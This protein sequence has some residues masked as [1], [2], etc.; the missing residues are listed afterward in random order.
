[1]TNQPHE[2]AFFGPLLLDFWNQQY[3]QS[4]RDNRPMS[5]EGARFRH[6]WAGWCARR[7]QYEI[8]NRE[9]TRT[10]TIPARPPADRWRLEM[11]T[12]VH[13]YWQAALQHALPDAT[14]EHVTQ[15]TLDNDD[16]SA[17][18]G[19]AVL[20]HPEFGKICVELKTRN[21][22][23]YK[24]DIGAAKSQVPEGPASTAKRQG[25]L[26][27]LAEDADLLVILHISLEAVGP[28][29]LPQPLTGQQYHHRRMTAEWWYTKEEYT[30]WAE[31]ELKRVSKIIEMTDAGKPAP[32]SVPELMPPGA[33]IVNPVTS[34][35][36]KE[37]DGIVVGTD[38]LW[39]GRYCDYCPFQ[40]ACEA[41]G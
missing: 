17:G 1:M 31:H 33:R 39:H 19:D 5:V 20:T 36:K 15:H 41:D 13:D 9:G 30:E 29:Q 21:G 18:H 6:S 27:A 24:T 40:E 35:W 2:P 7:I 37:V 16:I 25:A 8:Q 32:R 4:G 3:E 28:N 22:Y 10:F 26:N 23:G 34:Q 14:I 12:I 38:V 11:G